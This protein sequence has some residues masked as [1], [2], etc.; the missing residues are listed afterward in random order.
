MGRKKWGLRGQTT[1]V[2]SMTTTEN[3]RALDA[4]VAPAVGL[5]SHWKTMRR[6]CQREYRT[7]MGINLRWSDAAESAGCAAGRL[8]SE[9][10]H[11]TRVRGFLVGCAA[12]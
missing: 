3:S 8:G 9:H 12:R 2:F 10:R 5:D 11:P 7:L 6:A 4:C 1:S